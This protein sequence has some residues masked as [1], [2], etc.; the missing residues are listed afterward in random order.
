MRPLKKRGRVTITIYNNST[1]NFLYL[2]AEAASPRDGEAF[3]DVRG[4]LLFILPNLGPN[5]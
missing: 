4:F 3:K 5:E 2:D 1:H